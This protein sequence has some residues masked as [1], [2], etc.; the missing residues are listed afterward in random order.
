VDA[1]T[2]LSGASDSL[3][4][5][6][7]ELKE[8]FDAEIIGAARWVADYYPIAAERL[9]AYNHER[10]YAEQVKPWGFLIIAHPA[11]HE[12]PGGIRTLIGPFERDPVK[13]LHANWIDR[14]QPD[15]P[16]RRIHTAT[17]PEH[18]EGS[19][20][21]LSYRDYFNRYRQHP[22]SKALDPTDGKRCH[23]WTRGQLQ[24]WHITATEHVRVGKESNRLTDTHQSVDDVDEQ[25]IEYPAPARKCRGCDIIVSG[26][27]QWCSEAC[28]KRTQRAGSRC[29]SESAGCSPNGRPLLGPLTSKGPDGPFRL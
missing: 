11:D 5:D 19:I 29:D 27:R 4:H 23:P 25:V 2:V 8:R 22:E 12:R 14:D 16:A 10:P 1:I 6:D 9:A 26:K 7:R 20:Q 18:R 15:Q 17:T 13:R 21:V 28:R 3:G 24:P